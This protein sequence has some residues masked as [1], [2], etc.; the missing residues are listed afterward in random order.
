MRARVVYELR[1]LAAPLHGT[2]LIR[3]EPRLFFLAAGTYLLV[4]ESGCSYEGLIALQ[5]DVADT[6]LRGFLPVR[7]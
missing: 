3:N 2:I 4:K 6:Q 1:A 7:A 5:R